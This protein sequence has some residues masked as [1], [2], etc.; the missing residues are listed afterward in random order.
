MQGKYEGGL[1]ALIDLN[2][3]QIQRDL[4]ATAV[5]TYKRVIALNENALSILLGKMPHDIELGIPFYKQKYEL[6]IPI[7]I[8]SEILE[9]RP[10]IKQAEALYMAQNAQIGISEAMRWPSLNL[11]TCNL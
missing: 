10:D 6:D 11:V 5:P 1:I 8:P 9:R 3:A 4:A 2:Q 7:G